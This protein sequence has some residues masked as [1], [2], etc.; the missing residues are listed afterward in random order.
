MAKPGATA[1]PARPKNATAPTSPSVYRPRAN[2]LGSGKIAAAGSVVTCA[3]ARAPA[4]QSEVATVSA[5]LEG[6]LSG[7]TIRAGGAGAET[8]WAS[9]GT[10]GHRSRGGA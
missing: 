2:L 1:S 6:R 4:S 3:L 8:R 7:N 9:V 5:S 10:G